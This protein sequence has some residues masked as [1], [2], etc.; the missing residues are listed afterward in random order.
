[1]QEKPLVLKKIHTIRDLRGEVYKIL[2]K[3]ITSGAIEP[4]TQLKE[5]D[6]AEEMAVSRTPIRE[7]LNQLS[8]EGLVKIIP[9][10][11]AFITRWTK[12]EALEVLILRE[13]LEGLAGR[14]A[15]AK[16]SRGDIDGLE[17]L[18]TDYENGSLEYVEAD[19]RFHEAIVDACGMER[20]KELIWN[21]YDSLQM[22]KIL[23]LSFNNEER[24]AESM[25]EHRR[26]ISALRAG[27]ENEVERATKNNF[28][29]T[30]AI[31]EQMAEE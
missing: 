31:V 26:I 16:M 10:K 11:G 25:E 27:D 14:L 17:A 9:R 8:K 24:I 3:A 15:A 28:Q 7:A 18:M 21:L 30:R 6:L 19:K 12:Q 23:A 29:K 1:M 5:A 20:L 2:R 13:D 4:G 22:R